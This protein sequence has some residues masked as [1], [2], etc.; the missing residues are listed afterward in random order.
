MNIVTRIQVKTT[1]DIQ[2]VV[3]ITVSRLVKLSI[4][5]PSSNDVKVESKFGLDGSGNH[6]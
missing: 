2:K 4:M 6:N 3:K 1:A 5:I